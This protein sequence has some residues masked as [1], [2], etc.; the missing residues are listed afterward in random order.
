MIYTLAQIDLIGC[1]NMTFL[2]AGFNQSGMSLTLMLDFNR[3]A[4][5]GD[6]IFNSYWYWH[7]AIGTLPAGVY[8]L[9]IQAWDYLAPTYTVILSDEYFT[10]FQVVPEPSTIGLLGLGAG[11]LALRKRKRK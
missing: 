10:S 7:E 1:P 5:V 4:V 9:T 8:D 3:F 2:G 11:A 6:P